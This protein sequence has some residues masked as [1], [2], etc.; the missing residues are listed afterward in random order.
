M[1]QRW[2]MPLRQVMF[3]REMFESLH[4]ESVRQRSWMFSTATS[5]KLHLPCRNSGKSFDFMHQWTLSIQRGLRWSWSLRSIKPSLQACLWRSIMWN[6]CQLQR[7]KTSA[8]MPLP[9]RNLRKSVCSMFN[10]IGTSTWVYCWFRMLIA[11][12]MHKSTLWEPM[13]KG[14]YLH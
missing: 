14:K 4:S 7:R 6:E 13:H 9:W 12:S 5:C 8:Y 11:T 1:P 10:S 3:Q 2:W